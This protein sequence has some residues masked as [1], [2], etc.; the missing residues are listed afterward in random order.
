M[1]EVGRICRYIRVTDCK[2]APSDICEQILCDAD[3]DYLGRADYFDL[4]GKLRMEWQLLGLA[5][6]TDREWYEFQLDFLRKHV[7]HSPAARLLRETGKEKNEN[8][9][10]DIM[11]NI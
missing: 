10:V 4:A 11:L 9:L 8:M 5:S 2:I 7:Y 3:L 1:D 6:F